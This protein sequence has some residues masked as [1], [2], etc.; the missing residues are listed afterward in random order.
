VNDRLTDD[1]LLDASEIEVTV[2]NR[3]V[4]LAGSVRDR[5]ERR[6]A[7]DLAE[8]VPGVT[9]VQNN[10]RTGQHQA[11]HASGTEVGDSGVATGNPSIGAAG[12][13]GGSA[14]GGRQTGGNR[15]DRQRQST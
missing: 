7:E 4:T 6:R 15:T 9:H 3:E 5:N 13:A 2:Q 8:A 10:L 11:G 1:P 14:A 12:G